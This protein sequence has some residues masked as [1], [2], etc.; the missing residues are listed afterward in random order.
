MGQHLP[1]HSAQIQHLDASSTTSNQETCCKKKKKKKK[2]PWRVM[3]WNGCGRSL[4]AP[5]LSCCGTGGTRV[6]VLVRHPGTHSSE[7]RFRA[8]IYLPQAERSEVGPF[9]REERSQSVGTVGTSSRAVRAGPTP[10]FSKGGK[11]LA[12]TR[13]CTAYKKSPTLQNKWL[14]VPASRWGF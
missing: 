8:C 4:R 13:T 6:P 7:P 5:P 2:K 10:P 14:M 12:N 1:L 3:G 11:T 9:R